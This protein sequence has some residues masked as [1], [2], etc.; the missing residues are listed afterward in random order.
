[1]ELSAADPQHQEIVTS[2]LSDV[3]LPDRMRCGDGRSRH[4]DDRSVTLIDPLVGA[5]V[6]L[7][8][9]WYASSSRQKSRE[10]TPGPSP[11]MA[12]VVVTGGQEVAPERVARDLA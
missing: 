6:T 2:H 1:M 4:K 5:R 10:S 8:T 7:R 12:I 11:C 9:S 3:A